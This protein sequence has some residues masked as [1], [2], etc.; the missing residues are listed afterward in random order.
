[1]NPGEIIGVVVGVLVVLLIILLIVNLVRQ[2]K[3]NKQRRVSSANK[4]AFATLNAQH[5]QELRALEAE[6][7][8]K[9]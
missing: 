4:E 9:S 2:N 7:A 1:M 6:A 5:Q 8:R 3:K